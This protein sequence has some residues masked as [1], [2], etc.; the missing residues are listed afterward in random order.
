MRR[1]VTTSMRNTLLD[2]PFKFFCEYVRRLSPLVSPDYFRWGGLV[3]KCEEFVDN[4]L[5]V[6]DAVEE[7]RKEAESR[8]AQASEVVELEGM[9]ALVPRVVDAHYLKWHEED[10]F[11]EHLGVEPVFELLLPSGYLFKGRIDKIIRDTRNGEMAILERKTAAK[12]GEDFW[13]K[14]QLDPQPKGYCLA[15]QKAMGFNI[16]HVLYDVYKKPQIRQGK[17]ETGEMFQ[18]RLADTYLLKHKELFERRKITFT[19][20]E[21]DRYLYDIDMIAEEIDWR[22]STANWP[23]HCPS[24]RFGSCTFLPLCTRGDESKLRVRGKKELNPE[25]V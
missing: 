20:V 14:K 8:G 22:L 13:S 21:I 7:V 6:E 4:G 5:T 1:V 19:Q 23:Q 11:Y 3:H 24:N 15:A 25:L 18:K 2:C 17:K 16:R 10:E 12:T 9:C